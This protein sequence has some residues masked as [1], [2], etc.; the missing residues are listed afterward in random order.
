MKI[1][2]LVQSVQYG[3]SHKLSENG[4]GIPI[5]RMNNIGR[6]G[7]LN[8]S[9]MKTIEIDRKEADKFMLSPGDILFNRTNSRELVGKTAIYDADFKSVFASYL[10]RINVNRRIAT[11]NFVW[12]Y[13]NTGYMKRLL[14]KMARGAIGQANINSFELKQIPTY[15]PPK[16]LQQQFEDIVEMVRKIRNA[17]REC[18]HNVKVFISS[19]T[20]RIFKG[21]FDFNSIKL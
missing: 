1:G 4:A 10:I 17:R 9:E 16:E 12:R 2:D 15:L 19:L 8:L 21:N 5:L 7:F 18:H 6:D 14:F 11:P 3:L 20:E 13:L